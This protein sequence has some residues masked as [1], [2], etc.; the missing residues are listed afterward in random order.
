MRHRLTTD[1]LIAFETISH[2]KDEPAH[3]RACALFCRA[4]VLTQ[5]RRMA[6]APRLYSKAR[7]VAAAAMD[8]LSSAELNASCVIWIC[9]N[10]MT[11]ECIERYSTVSTILR[12]IVKSAEACLEDVREYLT[13]LA[14]EQVKVI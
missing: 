5:T 13:T 1:D 11:Q 6:N 9:T 8:S 12:S 14:D 4:T 7:V 2:R 3:N 10:A